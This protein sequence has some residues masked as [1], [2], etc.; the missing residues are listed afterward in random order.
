MKKYNNYLIERKKDKISNSL[1]LLMNNN[2]FENFKLLIDSGKAN[3]NKK[4]HKK[5][6]PIFYSLQY[7]YNKYEFSKYLIKKGANL[8]LV[9]EDGTPPLHVALMRKTNDEARNLTKMMIENGNINLNMKYHIYDET[10]DTYLT[11]TI[12][13]KYNFAIVLLIDNG[14]IP[15]YYDV[16]LALN[17]LKL[18]ISEKIIDA[19]PEKEIIKIDE[20]TGE[21]LL[22]ETYRPREIKALL[23]KGITIIPNNNGEYFWYDYTD[24]SIEKLDELLK[25]FPEQYK[26]FYRQRKVKDFNL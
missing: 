14:A 6:T 22:F 20:E 5:E 21:N 11:H 9:N 16:Y 26:I 4:N 1:F 3:I 18:N 13:Q 15:K 17:K 23:K 10:Y 19:T 12:H 24:E 8:N 2:D 7:W 25:E